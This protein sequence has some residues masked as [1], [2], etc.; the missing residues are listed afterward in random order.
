MK[1]LKPSYD[2]FKLRVQSFISVWQYIY[3]LKTKITDVE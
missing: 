1:T 2:P 3:D